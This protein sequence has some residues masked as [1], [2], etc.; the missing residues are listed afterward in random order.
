M[1]KTIYKP[2]ILLFLVQ[3]IIACNFETENYQQIPTEQAYQSL[4][5][6][7]NGMNG[8]YHALGSVEFLGSY[9]LI[10][11]DIC[12]DISRGNPTT[13]HF[14]QQT[15]WAIEDTDHEMASIWEYGYKVIDRCTRTI[16]GGKE[17]QAKADELHLDEDEMAELQSCIAQCYALRALA[18]YYLVNFFAYPYHLGTD[19]LGIPLVKDKP[20]EPFTTIARATVGETY[21]QIID[22]LTEAETFTK[23]S[24]I[25]PGAFYMGSMAIQA[26]KARVYM[27]KGEYNSAKT[28]AQKAIELKDK[29]NGTGNDNEPTDEAYINMWTSLSITSEDLFTIAKNES[30]N[31]GS[32]SL[33]SHYGEYG[34]TFSHQAIT[35]MSHNDIRYKLITKNQ[36]GTTTGKFKG[37]PTSAPTCNIPILRKS[38]M[39]L[40]IAEVE[41]RA[42]NIESAQ[43]YLFYTAKRNKDITSA[44][45]LPSTTDDLLNF[46]ANERVREFMGEGHRFFDARRM[47]LELTLQDFEVPFNIAG[48]V[49]PIPADEINAGFCTEQNEGWEMGLPQ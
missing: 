25:E 38:E 37:I 23:Q 22:D 26:L 16:Q 12:S 6:V 47:N 34:F 40:I 7:Q 21:K 36:Y 10:Y 33:N 9:A 45:M 49:F 24:G 5:D 17:I 19:N 35:L 8:A 2:L 44:Q 13:G 15:I 27:D 1:M 29:G 30:D 28:A 14:Y 32:S 42:G 43:D 11:G 46:I 3:G 48:F 41:A 18:N 20:V 31:L 39:S 4:Q